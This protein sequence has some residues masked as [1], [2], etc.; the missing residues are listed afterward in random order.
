MFVSLPTGR[1]A[2]TLIELL[3][4]IAIISILA[5]ILLPVFARAREAARRTTCTSNLKQ[6][7]MALVQYATDYDEVLPRFSQGT[8]DPDG[9]RGYDGGSGPRWGD[10]LFPYVKSL[11]VYNC[12]T[13]T[14]KLA[15]DTGGVW[16]DISTYSYGYVSPSSFG[17]G[18]GANYGVAGR[19]LAAFEDTSGTLMLVDDG[20][21]DA[22]GTGPILE[23]I[24]RVIPNAADDLASLGGRVDGMRHSGAALLDYQ[25]HWI[26][27][28][29]LDGH[30]KYVGLPKT[31]PGQWT[32]DAGD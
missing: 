10:S 30:A 15:Y 31:F 5:A 7:G 32:I 16:L 18:N 14:R 4:V 17:A 23:T 21:Q 22:S 28:A 2:F 25:N 29:Y 26:N 9:S 20:R 1:R 13:G 6:L 27:A 12:P 11:Q 19:S 3:V 24:G 8:L